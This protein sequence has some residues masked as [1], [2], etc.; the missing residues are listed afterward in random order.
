MTVHFTLAFD[1]K[2]SHPRQRAKG[3]G[4]K[5]PSEAGCLKYGPYGSV[6]QLRIPAVSGAAAILAIVSGDA[7]IAELNGSIVVMV[8]LVLLVG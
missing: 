7:L 1:L 3:R 2:V 4:R 6:V 5:A 8:L